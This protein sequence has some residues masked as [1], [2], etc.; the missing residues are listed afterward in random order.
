M[1]FLMRPKRSKAVLIQIPVLVTGEVDPS[2][3]RIIYHLLDNVLHLTVDNG[4]VEV[5]LHMATEE[6]FESLFNSQISKS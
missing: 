4:K 2:L 5:Q 6:E 3:S 1:L